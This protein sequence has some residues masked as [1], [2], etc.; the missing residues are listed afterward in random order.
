MRKLIVA[1]ALCMSIGVMAQMSV[2]VGTGHIWTGTGNYAYNLDSAHWQVHV[3]GAY[4]FTNHQAVRL[5]VARDGA[6][7]VNWLH[8]HNFTRKVFNDYEYTVI[9]LGYQ[10][11]FMPNSKASPFAYGGL[12]EYTDD[13]L[14][15]SGFVVGGGLRFN[16]NKHWYI[17]TTVAYRHVEDF[18]VPVANVAE[19]RI[20]IGWRW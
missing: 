6:T 8:R 7:V 12:S 5:D 4:N 1:V 19:T 13:G 18:I 20:G 15:K 11:T 9:D 10:Y 16:L 2:E 14:W 3:G 17:S